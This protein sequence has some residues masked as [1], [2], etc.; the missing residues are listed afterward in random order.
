MKLN[1]YS[2]VIHRESRASVGNEASGLAVLEAS[3][4]GSNDVGQ[5]RDAREGQSLTSII[6]PRWRLSGGKDRERNAERV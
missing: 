4:S 6:T 2:P 3:P 5:S 1:S